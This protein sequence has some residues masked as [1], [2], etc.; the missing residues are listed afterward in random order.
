MSGMK[1]K[2]K[3]CNILIVTGFDLFCRLSALPLSDPPGD[4]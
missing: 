1:E 3:A 2:K 4:T